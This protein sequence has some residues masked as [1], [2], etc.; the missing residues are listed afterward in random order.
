MRFLQKFKGKAARER[1]A[2][3]HAWYVLQ[4]SPQKGPG[5]QKKKKKMGKKM[6]SNPR[7]MER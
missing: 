7:A 3:L 1:G 5:I 4:V 2:G 6:K